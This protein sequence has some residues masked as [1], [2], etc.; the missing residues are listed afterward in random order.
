LYNVWQS[1]LL[2]IYALFDK[3]TQG[4]CYDLYSRDEFNTFQMFP[5]LGERV[6]EAGNDKIRIKYCPSIK[7]HIHR[8]IM[9][10]ENMADILV[11]E[12]NGLS[13]PE[14]LS[15]QVVNLQKSN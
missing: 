13:R 2:L 6:I 3:E 1:S 8:D 10:A 7:V 11:Y 12:I 9:A 15:R 14:Y 4:T 5:E